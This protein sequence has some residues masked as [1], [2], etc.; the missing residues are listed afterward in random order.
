MLVVVALGGN[1]LL[2][3][4][5]PLDMTTQRRNLVSAAGAIADLA[6][7]HD[8]LV[9]HGNGPQ[10]GFLALQGTAAGSPSPL[11]VLGAETE[12]M[13]GYLI[14]QVL[15]QEIPCR[16]IASL[17][18][19]TIVRVDDPAFSHPTKPIGPV[20]SEAEAAKLAAERGWMFAADGSFQRRVVPSPEPRAIVEIE[21]IRILVRHGVLVIAAGGGGI[22]VVAGSAGA[23]HGVEAV[24]DKDLASAL[25]ASQLGAEALLLLTDVPAVERDWGTPGAAPIRVASPAELRNLHFEAG[26]MAPKVEAACRFVEAGGKMAGIG[27][28]S[29]AAD[30]LAGRAGTVVRMESSS[31][32]LMSAAMT[33]NALHC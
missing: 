31:P 15:R 16:E 11:D 29:D 14:E 4:G 28:L 5:E 9:T 27:S 17:L 25:L 33:A 2:R 12:G 24:V 19:Q 22:P 6:D 3:R 7:K 18:T 10:I 32:G 8:L 13:I 26:S 21:T 30:I 23:L 1:A 20:Y